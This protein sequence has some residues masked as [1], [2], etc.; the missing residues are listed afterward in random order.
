M[1]QEKP[2]GKLN[3]DLQRLQQESQPQLRRF[4]APVA[5]PGGLEVFKVPTVNG[6]VV[7][8]AIAKGSSKKLLKDLKARGLINGSAYG[9]VVS[10]MMPVDKLGSLNSV[11]S[12]LSASPAL[13][14]ANAGL[15]TSQGDESLGS[16]MVR[17]MYGIDGSGVKVG[18]LSDS[19]DCAGTGGGA[20][21]DVASGDLPPGVEVLED[22]DGGCS[23]EGRAMMQL[24]HDVAPGSDQ[25]FHTAFTGQAGFANGILALQAAGSKVIVDDVGYFAEP[26]FQDGII[27]Q[28]AQIV[29]DNGS[30]FFSS[31]GNNARNS[32]ESAFTLSSVAGPWTGPLHDWNPGPEEDPFLMFTL[33]GNG[34]VTTIILNWDEPYASAGPA[35]A[36]TDL[37]LW[38]FIGGVPFFVSADWNIGAD[39]IEILQIGNPGP[40]VDV[41]LALEY[42]A[43]PGPNLVKI[44]HYGSDA[45]FGEGAQEYITN[46]STSFGHSNAA[47]MAGVGASAYFNTAAFNS[48][49]MPAC[50]NYFSSAGGTPILFDG[51]ANP[52]F[53]VR[54]RPNFVGPDGGNTTFFGFDFEPDGWPNFFGTSASAPH[55][56][57]VAALMLQTDSSLTPEEIYGILQ[58]TAEDMNAPGFDFDTGHGFVRAAAAVDA[59]ATDP[60]KPHKRFVCHK[61]GKKFK[62]ISVAAAAVSA[63]VGHG[64]KFGPC[65]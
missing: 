48:N 41:E 44:I 40:S 30:A 7:I 1:A 18:T 46:S 39:P 37:D 19:Y 47:N 9:R 43:G 21:A 3:G 22:I 4:A 54:D 16:D 5:N 52:I 10:G 26:M 35:G 45:A 50:L 49:C 2:A 24:I 64:D 55:V 36:E 62:T 56:A 31:A 8:D 12:L 29:A 57:A 33:E 59:V 23:D 32:I 58:D 63:H 53:E 13:S 11:S 14:K 15:V 51:D 61:Q 65:D 34:A 42:F 6:Y 28:A 60:R 25:A 27:A 38:M 17:S 20:A